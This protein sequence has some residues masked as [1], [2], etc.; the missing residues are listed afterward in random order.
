M[1][2]RDTFFGR[3][4]SRPTENPNKAAAPTANPVAANSHVAPPPAAST[5]D[6]SHRTAKSAAAKDGE[7]HGSQ[8]IIG[9]KIR[10]KGVEIADCDTLVVE[11]HVEATMDSRVIQIAPDGTFTGTA[12]IDNAEIR[13]TFSGELTVRKCLNIHAT[14]KVSGKIRYNKMIIE[15]GGEICG[16]VVKLT[17]NGQYASARPASLS[18]KAA[19]AQQAPVLH[20]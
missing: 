19:T 1:L 13:G 3:Q 12:A 14:G 17:E 2:Q 4:P 6:D 8:M 5:T 11:G 16:E 15:E 7:P 10:M 20:S 9:P 18:G